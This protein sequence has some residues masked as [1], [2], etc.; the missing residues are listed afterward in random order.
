M[1]TSGVKYKHFVRWNLT[2][3]TGNSRIMTSTVTGRSL[4]YLTLLDDSD[5]LSRSPM[6]SLSQVV[7]NYL[8]WEVN[9]RAENLLHKWHLN[10]Y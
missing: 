6:N 7:R 4:R 2:E 1:L 3:A 9:F 10:C 5:F 8:S